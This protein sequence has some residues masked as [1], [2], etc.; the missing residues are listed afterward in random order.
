MA[1]CNGDC[2]NCIYPDC[3]RSFSQ[4]DMYKDA[5]KRYEQSEKGKQNMRRKQKRRIENGKNAEYCREYYRRHREEIL[6]KKKEARDRE[7]RKESIGNHPGIHRSI[8]K[9]SR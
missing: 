7:K 1:V 3:I 5:H 4:Y 9:K 2:F 8:A 6:K